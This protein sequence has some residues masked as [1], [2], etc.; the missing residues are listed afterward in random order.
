MTEIWT[1]V[2]PSSKATRIIATRGPGEAILKATLAPSPKHHRALP[3]L[4]EAIALWEGTLVRG[5]LVA[6]ERSI[7]S[8]TSICH[9]YFAEVDGAPLYTLDMVWDRG[10]RRRADRIH[11]MG[12]FDDLRRVLREEVAR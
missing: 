5:A 10:R 7:T 6:D 9:S 3:A 2:S 1:A 4:L 12:A 11:G 8:G